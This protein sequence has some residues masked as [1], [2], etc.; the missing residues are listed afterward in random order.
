MAEVAGAI[1]ETAPLEVESAMP[2][3]HVPA[4]IQVPWAGTQPCR[5]FRVWVGMT[6]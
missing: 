3:L 2:S 6:Y 4:L 1:W 5:G